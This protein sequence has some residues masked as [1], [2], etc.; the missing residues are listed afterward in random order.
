MNSN[1]TN[2]IIKNMNVNKNKIYFTAKLKNGVNEYLPKGDY[3]TS[4]PTAISWQND[5]NVPVYITKYK[6]IYPHSTEPHYSQMYHS[7]AFTTKI[8][9][10]QDLLF[11]T[12]EEPYIEMT[13][14]LDY[15][16]NDGNPNEPKKS[17]ATDQCWCFSNDFTEAPIKLESEQR[18]GHYIAG[19]FSSENIGANPIGIIEGYYY[20]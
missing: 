1:K 11:Y 8:G 4:P 14:N 16:T 12:F 5:K 17:W 7:T 18:F 3:S 2:Q 20:L 6:F 13:S 9:I 10:I 19:D 15:L